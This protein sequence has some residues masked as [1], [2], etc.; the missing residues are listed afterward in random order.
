MYNMMDIS[1]PAFAV[2]Y[3]LIM[4]ITGSFFALNLI[5]AAIID[6][7]LLAKDEEERRVLF[8]KHRTPEIV[9]DDEEFVVVEEV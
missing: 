2:T 5:L 9:F 1:S 4:I 8:E 6:A 7:Y 3:S